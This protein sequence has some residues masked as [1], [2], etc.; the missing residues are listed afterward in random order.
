MS[1]A[2]E[3]ILL[4]AGIWIWAGAGTGCQCLGCS[5]RGGNPAA[6]ISGKSR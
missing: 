2:K 5:T 3:A 4:W 1:K 6:S